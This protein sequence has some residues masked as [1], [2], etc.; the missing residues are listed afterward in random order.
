M[1]HVTHT[2]SD[3]GRKTYHRH[4]LPLMAE[5]S[6]IWMKPFHTYQRMSHV[7]YEW[8]MSHINVSRHTHEHT[9]EVRQG[10]RH[11]IGDSGPR[12]NESCYIWMSPTT[13][14]NTWVFTYG[15]DMSH[16]WTHQ[17]LVMPY[18][19]ESCH[20]LELTHKLT[21][22]GRHTVSTSSRW[23]CDRR[24]SAGFYTHTHTRTHTVMTH[25]Y[26][27]THRHTHNGPRHPVKGGENVHVPWLFHTCDVKMYMCH[28]SFTCGIWR[29][30]RAITL[31][32]YVPWPLHMYKCHD[33]LT[34]IYPYTCISAMTLSHVYMPWLFHMCMCHD[35]FTCVC[36]MTLSYVWCDLSTCVT[37][38]IHR[39][40]V[41][42]THRIP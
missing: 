25:P 32:V 34:C 23:G 27:D 13:H 6:H 29:C 19:N 39:Y 20:T 15:W 17:S 41:A 24:R 9:Y 28:D 14:M 31:Y 8:V 3:T 7:S 35:S 36:A 11:T 5:S 12:M 42:K 1:S 21:Q 30:T 18:M 26:N 33:S 38:C 10:R 40:R 37:W 4:E 2:S 22:G 16:I